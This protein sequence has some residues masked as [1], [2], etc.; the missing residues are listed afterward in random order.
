MFIEYFFLVSTAQ[1][2]RTYKRRSVFPISTLHLLLL[3]NRLILTRMWRGKMAIT[4]VFD[5]VMF[6]SPF[7]FIAGFL[8]FFHSLPFSIF[9]SSSYFNTIFILFDYCV[10]LSARPSVCV[11]VDVC[12]VWSNRMAWRYSGFGFPQFW[13]L[14]FSFIRTRVGISGMYIV[15]TYNA[16]TII[17]AFILIVQINDVLRIRNISQV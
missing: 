13:L 6:F 3:L 2:T 8:S 14:S 15:H 1:T 7:F 12:N 4:L 9:T 10:C 5:R 11:C 16:S 17:Y